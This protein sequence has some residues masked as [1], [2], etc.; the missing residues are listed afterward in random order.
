LIPS[1]EIHK[2]DKNVYLSE[3]NDLKIYLPSEDMFDATI[4]DMI[5][6]INECSLIIFDSVNSFYNLYYNGIINRSNN[7]LKIGNLNQLLYFILMLILKHTSEC[8]IPFL[9][10]SMVRYRRKEIVTT[11]RLLSKKSSLNFYVKIKN[12][13]DL[14]VTILS[15]SKVDQKSFIMK[16]KVLRW[17]RTN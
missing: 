1:V 4:V 10:T 16:D 7:I 9:V 2:V 11:N 14:S 8:N 17:N 6:S 12:L 13:N 3:S 5:K 15:E